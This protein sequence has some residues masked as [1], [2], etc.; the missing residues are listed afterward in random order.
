MTESVSYTKTFNFAIHIFNL[1]NSLC[2]DK[3]YV[4]SKQ[5]LRSGTSIGAKALEISED[6]QISVFITE[7][8]LYF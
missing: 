7:D 1:Y 2:T 8:P 5:L 4:L 6:K 3:E